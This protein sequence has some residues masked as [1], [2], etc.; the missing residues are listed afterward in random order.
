[1]RFRTKMVAAPTFGALFHRVGDAYAET[2]S[3]EAEM[4]VPPNEMDDLGQPAKASST[5]LR[6]SLTIAYR[7]ETTPGPQGSLE[8][9]SR[10]ICCRSTQAKRRSGC[11]FPHQSAWR[12]SAVI[13]RRVGD[14]F[15]STE[16][17]G[18]QRVIRRHQSGKQGRSL[19]LLAASLPRTILSA[20][21]ADE[22][23]TALLAR[24]EMQSWRLIQ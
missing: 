4:L 2:M 22:S 14:A 16:G 3:F 18:S 20:A 10:S 12:T 7:N 6:Y 24:R 17:E 8:F 5:F 23:P 21:N 19:R 9:R 15:I 13:D 11:P 1:M